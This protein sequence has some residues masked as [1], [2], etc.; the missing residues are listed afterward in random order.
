MYIVDMYRM[1]QSAIYVWGKVMHDSV[2][3][4]CTNRVPK[5]ERFWV[6]RRPPTYSDGPMKKYYCCTDCEFY[7]LCTLP[8]NLRLQSNSSQR[9]TVRFQVGSKEWEINASP[10]MPTRGHRAVGSCAK[11][12]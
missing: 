1:S 5:A 3:G 12:L 7:S 2:G 11:K 10:S 4:D 9:N 8:P 6:E